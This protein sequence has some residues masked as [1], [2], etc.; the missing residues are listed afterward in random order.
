MAIL[1]GLRSSNEIRQEEAAVELAEMLLLGNEESL[2]NLPVREI[3]QCL[4]TLLQKKHNFVLMLASARCII[5]MLEALPRSLPVIVEAVPLLIEKLK[6]IEYIDVA[7]QSLI[8]LE[9]M[10]K[11]NGKNIML[12]G[13]IAATISHVD[14]FSL[15]SQRL[16]FQ[17]A[18]NC[19]LYVTAHDFSHVK[20]ALTDLTQRFGMD[21]K[22]S[23]ESVCLLFSR[24]VDNM[25]VHPEK[26]REIAGEDYI[27]LK[28]VQQLAR[29]EWP[30]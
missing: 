16:A 4:L 26:L 29:A 17:I 7:E 23:L 20:D 24:L 21:D 8:A 19:A 15:P 22:R 5:N 1:E 12:Q 11:R 14:S 27:F 9:V 10:S 13:G 28:N 6:R 25:K 18:A 30:P 3:L 2:P